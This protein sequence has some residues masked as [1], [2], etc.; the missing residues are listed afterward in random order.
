MSD[1]YEPIVE[2][3]TRRIEIRGIDYAVHEW[4]GPGG[5]LLACLHGWGD[6]GASFQFVADALLSAEPGAWH[7]IAPDWRGFGDSS[8]NRSAY[9]YPDY[10]AD[11]H[12]LLGVYSPAE[13][14]SILGHSMGGNVAG[15]YAGAFPERVSVFVNAEGFGL[16]DSD[17]G[18]AP[19]RYRSWIERGGADETFS[20]YADF[21]A[22]ADKVLKRNPAMTK[23]RARFVARSWAV[24]RDGRVVL[25]ADPKHRWPNAVLYRRAEAEAC[26]RAVRAPVLMVAGE[27]S[28]FRNA[29][30]PHDGAFDFDLPFPDMRSV[31]LPGCGHMLH[32]EAPAALA[33]ATRDF[34]AEKV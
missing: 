5:R 1:E 11:L 24:E 10:A 12:A 19:S 34:I 17:P 30:H 7:V 9:W 25:K 27:N 6:T 13:P 33:D 23:A 8:H 21:D 16:R 32:F 2:R 18:D 31:V 26:W 20:E 28:S 29:G 4:G 15:L 14:A 3:V 22:L